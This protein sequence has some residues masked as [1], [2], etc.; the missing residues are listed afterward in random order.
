[1]SKYTVAVVIVPLVLVIFTRPFSIREKLGLLWIAGVS[2]AGAAIWCAPALVLH[3]DKILNELRLVAQLYRNVQLPH[4][5]WQAALSGE[6]LGWPLV[7]CGFGGLIAMLFSRSLRPAAVGW[8]LFAGLL[9]LPL[10]G[11]KH[12]PFRNLLPL[13]PLVCVAAAILLASPQVLGGALQRRRIPA[14]ALTIIAAA[15]SIP[16]FIVSS[17]YVRERLAR[18]DTRV[19]AVDWLAAHTRAGERVLALRELVFVPSELARVPAAVR[20]I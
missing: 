16:A 15:I 14:I 13:V 18:V 2:L 1:D 20:E 3:P 8:I 10:F 7:V 19:L 5:Y 4:D 12:Q 11:Y 6:E 17:G 9:I